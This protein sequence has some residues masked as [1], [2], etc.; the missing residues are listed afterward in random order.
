MAVAGYDTCDINVIILG[1]LGVQKIQ[2][3]NF[4]F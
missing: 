4:F 2:Y 3:K 1:F